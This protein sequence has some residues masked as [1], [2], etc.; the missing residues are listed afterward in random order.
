[1]A[2]ASVAAAMG[3]DPRKVPPSDFLPPIRAKIVGI[4]LQ[5]GE[6][7]GTTDIF[8]TPAFDRAYTGKAASIPVAVIVL[9]RHLLDFP[10]F[11]RARM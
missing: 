9:R 2:K 7:Q 8:L 1:M 5:Q 10:A 6:I 3:T 4:V 11:S